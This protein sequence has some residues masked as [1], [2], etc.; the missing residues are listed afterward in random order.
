MARQFTRGPRRT[1]Q[2]RMI[3]SLGPR[4][5]TAPATVFQGSIAFSE[6]ATV[7]RMLG[8]Y[9]IGPTSAPVA[10]DDAAVAIGIGVVSTDAA[11]VGGASMPDPD[12]EGEYPWL[13][14]ANHPLFYATTNVDHAVGTGVVRRSFD[15]RSMRKIKPRESLVVVGEYTSASGNPPVTF[16]MQDVRVLLA[17][18]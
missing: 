8:E 17:L 18:A 10:G 13:Y 3:E 6:A 16:F 14:W 1:K 5:F 2:W 15:I 11:T 7:L 4:D 12:T 9:V